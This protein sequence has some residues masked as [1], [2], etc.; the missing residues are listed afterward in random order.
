MFREGLVGHET[1]TSFAVAEGF[2]GK[3]SGKLSAG[4]VS[5]CSTFSTDGVEARKVL[6]EV[7]IV[8]TSYRP[9]ERPN[10]KRTFTMT[11]TAGE[12]KL[13]PA[14]DVTSAKRKMREKPNQTTKQP[15]VG[16]L[17]YSLSLYHHRRYS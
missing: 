4:G 13:N 1:L 7:D 5:V 10:N 15:S 8:F 17:T 6:D 14:S 11:P 3:T 12:E 9:L 16:E 2:E